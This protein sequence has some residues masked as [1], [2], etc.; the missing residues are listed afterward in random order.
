MTIRRTDKDP[1]SPEQ[2]EADERLLKRFEEGRALAVPAKEADAAARRVLA[3]YRE[4]REEVG[5][6]GEQMAQLRKLFGFTQEDVAKAIGTSKP[7]IC[8]FEKGRSPGITLERLL[9]MMEAIR[10]PGKVS[11][12]A[13]ARRPERDSLAPSAQ[14]RSLEEAVE[15]V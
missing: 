7:N 2:R 10:R 5:R 14:V 3:R 4:R 13:R 12:R 8:A 1:R 11:V 6:L 15:A 9:A